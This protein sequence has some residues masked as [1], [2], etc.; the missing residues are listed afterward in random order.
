[1]EIEELLHAQEMIAQ[2]GL[3]TP[4]CRFYWFEGYDKEREIRAEFHFYL[5]EV[6][7]TYRPASKEVILVSEADETFD[8][9]VENPDTLRVSGDLL[10]ELYRIDNLI[11]RC[12]GL[13]VN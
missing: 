13:S 5:H 9:M 11:R 10:S 2:V 8:S 4:C 7:L 3:G 12:K 6:E 1:M